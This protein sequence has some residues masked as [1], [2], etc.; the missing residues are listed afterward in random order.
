MLSTNEIHAAIRA[1]AL[2]YWAK[3]IEDQTGSLVIRDFYHRAGWRWLAAYKNGR[4]HWCGMFAGN[5]TLNIGHHIEP[6]Q[7][8]GVVI[9]PDIAHF[10][11]P[12]T[13]RLN[14]PRKW[15]QATPTP[16]IKFEIPPPHYRDPHKAS[17]ALKASMGPE[18]VE[19]LIPGAIATV[20]SRGLDT[21]GGHILIVDSYDG[22]LEF[23]TIEG[24]AWGQ[25]GNGEHGEGVIRRKRYISDLRRVYHLKPQ[26]VEET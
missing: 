12:S 18:L 4:D 11:T 24:N 9:D 7:C 23:T 15:A 1:A 13:S 21:Y 22:G 16:P 6:D 10:V 5:C 26:H 25:L 8:V 17:E 14:N 20:T 19:A 3:N 2:A